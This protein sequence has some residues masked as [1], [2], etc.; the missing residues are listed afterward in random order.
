[1]AGSRP[2]PTRPRSRLGSARRANAKLK[3]DEQLAAFVQKSK[4][5]G[6]TP[7]TFQDLV[8]DKKDLA[9]RSTKIALHGFYKSIGK[10]EI[11]FR[12]II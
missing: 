3:Y 9:S 10:N 2:G 1:V 4:D 5:K 7:I 8:L 11:V 6:Y 12:L